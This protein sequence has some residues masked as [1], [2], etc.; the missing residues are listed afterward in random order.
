MPVRRLVILSD[1]YRILIDFWLNDPNWL[2]VIF[3]IQWLFF[4]LLIASQKFLNIHVKIYSSF[5][6]KDFCVPH[7]NPLAAVF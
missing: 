4:L 3:S 1:L 6:F 7:K 2:V 5:V